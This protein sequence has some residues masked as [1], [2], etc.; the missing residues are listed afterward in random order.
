MI[1]DET[2]YIASVGSMGGD[3]QPQLH[4]QLMLGLDEG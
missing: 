3:I 4:V 2:G 1:E